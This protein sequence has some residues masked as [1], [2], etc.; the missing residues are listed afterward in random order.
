V[1]VWLDHALG[2]LAYVYLGAG[3]MFA[4]TGTA[5]VVCRYD[6][7]VGFFR[8]SASANMLIL[9]ACF[10]AGGI[11]VGRPYCRYLC[12]Y[13]AILGIVS[14][15]SK[16]HVKIPPDECIQCRL[17]E[18]AC[19]YGAIREPTATMPAIERRRGRRRLALLLVLF[20]AL[21]A[22][23]FCLGRQLEVRLAKVHPTVRLADRIRLEQTGRVDD[24]IDASDAFRNTGRA[25][26][27]LYREAFAL[28]SR[29]RWAGGWF[30]A[31][32][33]LVVGAKL[34]HLSVR[35]RR[36][37][38]QPNP[39]ACVSCGRCFWY[40]PGEQARQGWIQEIKPI[41]KGS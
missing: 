15:W 29:F 3:V 37:D 4:A 6:P 31:W 24:T 40:C 17:C 2:L 38:Y 5:F 25:T 23:G 27:N 39:A 14:R 18:A 35:R 12:P 7:F 1:P 28:S 10:L 26:D 9:G 20:P 16:W 21:V 19:P 34:I 33:G 11:F 41:A 13:G 8:H 32:V 30:G 22:V 36:S